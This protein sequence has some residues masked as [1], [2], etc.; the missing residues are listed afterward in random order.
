MTCFVC[1]QSCWRNICQYSRGWS[2][3]SHSYCEPPAG[4]T[5]FH[6]SCADRSLTPSHWV[7]AELWLIQLTQDI[8]EL[9]KLLHVMDGKFTR[10]TP[11]KQLSV[12]GPHQQQ[13][14][15]ALSFGS[16]DCDAH[17]HVFH[18]H[19]SP[20]LLKTYCIYRNIAVM[21]GME[22][23]RCSCFQ[24]ISRGSVLCSGKNCVPD[25]C[26]QQGLAASAA[27]RSLDRE[28]VKLLVFHPKHL[29][30]AGIHC[31]LQSLPWLTSAPV[32]MPFEHESCWRI[33]TVCEEQR[34]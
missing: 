20:F 23:H 12:T 4:P 5:V 15:R 24:G 33:K 6:L 34:G 8:C 14:C 1:S 21:A 31:W 17:M 19:S 29:I 7:T 10:W 9:N 32:R 18:I 25:N 13:S 22:M 16:F 11:G 3:S 2:K 30:F 28:A 27:V 26:R